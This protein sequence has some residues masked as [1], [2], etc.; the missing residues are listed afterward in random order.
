MEFPQYRISTNGKN[1]YRIESLKA[2]TELQY[3]GERVQSF[4][5]KAESYPEMV[6]IRE[7]L[8]MSNGACQEMDG[9]RFERLIRDLPTG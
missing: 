6:R 9:E 2:F 3:I 4:H 8:E 1:L 5:V 7:L